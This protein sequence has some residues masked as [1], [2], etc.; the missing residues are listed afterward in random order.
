MISFVRLIFCREHSLTSILILRIFIFIN[1]LSLRV[2]IL[3]L[4]K[5]ITTVVFRGNVI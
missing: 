3:F 4:K 2:D 5:I 1:I